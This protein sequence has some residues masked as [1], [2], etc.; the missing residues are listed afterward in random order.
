MKKVLIAAAM[1]AVLTITS[2][3]QESQ[4]QEQQNMKGQEQEGTPEE[5]QKTVGFLLNIEDVFALTV[6]GA[7]VVGTVE[8]G[9]A[10]TGD[11]IYVV[12]ADGTELETC[13]LGIEAFDGMT[14]EAIE[15]DSVGI[16]LDGLEKEQITP[17]DQLIGYLYVTD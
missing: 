3:G 9:R 14:E 15:G 11:T 10:R 16:L 6:P 5:D 4:S 7:V 2:C 13:I 17:G 8:S 1:I 12:K